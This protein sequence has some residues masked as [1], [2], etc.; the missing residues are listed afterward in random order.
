M[1]TFAGI[2][3]NCLNQ[4]GDTGIVRLASVALLQEVIQGEVLGLHIA[5]DGRTFF[6][7]HRANSVPAV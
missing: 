4:A 5:P 6:P 1:V 3:L 2:D 7:V